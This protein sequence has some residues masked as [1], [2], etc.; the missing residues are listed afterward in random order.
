MQVSDDFNDGGDI[1]GTALMGDDPRDA[2]VDG[3]CR[4]YDH[5]NLF[6]AGGAVLPSIGSVNCTLTI[7]A[8]ALRLAGLLQRET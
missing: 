5:P 6:L 1:A 8:L 2:V 7:A 4:S 3:D